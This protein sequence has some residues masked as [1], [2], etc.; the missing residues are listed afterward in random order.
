M[1]ESWSS[2]FLLLICIAVI[3]LCAFNAAT[4][5]KIANENKTVG[6]VTPGGALTL[7]VINIIIA[8]VFLFPVF[9]YARRFYS[10]GLKG[11]T[12]SW[13]NLIIILII[14]ACIILT[15]FNAATYG[16]IANENKTVGDVTPGGARALMI[17]NIILCII[18]FIPLGYYIYKMYKTPD[19]VVVEKDVTQMDLSGILRRP[20]EETRMVLE[21]SRRVESDK[22]LLQELENIERQKS[23]IIKRQKLE[24]IEIQALENIERQAL[25]NIEMQADESRLNVNKHYSP[26]QEGI[27]NY[28]R[29]SIKTIDDMDVVYDVVC[30]PF[31]EIRSSKCNGF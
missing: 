18:F 3:I 23:E 27:I 15:A 26:K 17:I 1:K 5:G 9:V 4:Y 2:A 11:N 6:D 25:E 22:E 31:N 29:N 20:S 7:M 16:K 10:S 12:F 14:V 28:L 19:N 13:V 8:V 24:D 21:Q 30:N